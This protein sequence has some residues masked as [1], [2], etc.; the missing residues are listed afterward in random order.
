MALTYL[1]NMLMF[2]GTNLSFRIITCKKHVLS[3]GF[4]FPLLRNVSK[5]IVQR[6]GLDPA[7]LM[8]D[9]YLWFQEWIVLYIPSQLHKGMGNDWIQQ[10]QR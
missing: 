4:S 10:K 5:R 3:L 8:V 7:A 2:V 1:R 9:V 6:W